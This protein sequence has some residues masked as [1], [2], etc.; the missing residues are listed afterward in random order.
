ME[1]AQR[2]EANGGRP[3]AYIEETPQWRDGTK[4][5][6]SVQGPFLPDKPVP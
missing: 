5:V 4:A 6:P 3:Q 1:P 2:R